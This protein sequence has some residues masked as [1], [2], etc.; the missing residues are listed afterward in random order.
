MRVL[1]TIILLS[2][3]SLIIAQNS[4][5]IV[6][7]DVSNKEVYRKAIHE[8][9]KNIIESSNYSKLL[10]LINNKEE[11]IIATSKAD[12]SYKLKSIIS[13]SPF[14]P[15]YMMD[16]ITIDSIICAQDYI[17]NINAITI[18]D[19]L[20]NR[21]TFYLFFNNR[22]INVVPEEIEREFIRPLLF[23]NKLLFNNQLQKN[24]SVQIYL[25]ASNNGVIKEVNYEKYLKKTY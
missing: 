25:Q 1:I 15:D 11:M 9:V 10:I 8:K 21:L 20:E 13:S 7:V 4:I 19:G 14:Y 6:Y 5:A 22:M 12:A 24:C 17:K 16:V 2:F 3:S 18:G 23:S